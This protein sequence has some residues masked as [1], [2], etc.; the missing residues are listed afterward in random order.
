MYIYLYIFMKLTFFFFVRVV[1]DNG[2]EVKK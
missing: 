1:G 2:E